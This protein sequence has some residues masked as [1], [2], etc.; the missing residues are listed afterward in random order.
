MGARRGRVRAAVRLSS[1]GAAARSPSIAVA[2]SFLWPGLGQLYQGRRRPAALY[3]L[4]VLVVT[5]LLLAQLIGGVEGFAAS[6]LDPSVAL[7]LIILVVLLGVWRLI[8]MGDALMVNRTQLDR[9]SLAVP[10]TALLTALVL[11]THAWVGSVT[12]A[13]YDAGSEIFVGQASPDASPGSG[14]PSIEPN[15]SD[16]SVDFQA[17]PFP[18][19]ESAPS[20]RITMLVTGIDSGHGREHSL[21]DTLM[22]VSVNADTGDVAMLSFP[23]DISNFPLYTGGTYKAKINSFM[24]YARLHPTEFPDGG[25]PTLAQEIGYLAGVPVQ[26]FAAINLEGFQRMIDLVGG[27]DVD[28]PRA[29]N[30]PVYDWFDGTK[31]FHLAAGPVH[32]NGRIGLAYV[33]SRYGAGDNDFTRA[34]RQQQVLAALRK[35]LTGP[36]ILTRLPELVRAAGKSVRTN[37]PVANVKDLI[38]IA[39]KVTDKTTVKKVL[40]PPYA[41]HPPTNTTGG[42]YTLRLDMDRIAKL[43]IEL[44]GSD[45]RYAPANEARGSSPPVP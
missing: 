14:L 31:G 29:I 3:A 42:I 37:Y 4:P 2:L 44:F 23:R 18:T 1:R 9:R 7:T 26:Y 39:G 24:T 38:D 30:D 15:S 10:I 32:L 5:V 8:A 45:S 16:N 35:K 36:T 11:A 28:N 17:T 43:S 40:G 33:R 21:T 27:V 19:P 34:A 20:N 13:F 25:L 22:L 6:L 12:W 41:I